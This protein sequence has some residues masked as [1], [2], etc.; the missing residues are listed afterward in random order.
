MKILLTTDINDVILNGIISGFK[1]H[2]NHELIMWNFD[3]ISMSDVIYHNKDIKI[4]IVY[5]KLISDTVFEIC[6]K[7]NIKIISYGLTNHPVDVQLI[8]DIDPELYDNINGTYY[9]LDKYVNNN[10]YIG[11]YNENKKSTLLVLSNYEMPKDFYYKLLD[12]VNYKKP[13]DLKIIGRCPVDMPQYLGTT[14]SQ[15]TIL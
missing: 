14:T 8:H 9:V 15:E 7:N 2:L 12:L 10:F 3:D 4:V 1:E 11:S 6:R 5:A 13:Y